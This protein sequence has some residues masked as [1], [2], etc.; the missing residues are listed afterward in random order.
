MITV[1]CAGLPETLFE[2]ELFGH[3]KG[4]FTGATQNK[5]GLL[6]QANDGT[7]FLDEIGDVPLGM[8]VK[9]LRL[10][11][12]GSYRVVG[13]TQVRSV[14]FRLICATHKNL[15]Q[16]VDIGKFREDLY[17]RINVFPINL[18][19]LSERQ[20]DIPLIANSLL[21]KLS[22]NKHYQLTEKS[23]IRLKQLTY[24]GN[25]RQLRNL[26]ERAIIYAKSNIIDVATIEQCIDKDLSPHAA[27]LKEIN[28]RWVDLKTQEKN[29]L[30][31][32][33]MHF[34]GDKALTAKHAGISVR[35]L[36]RKLDIS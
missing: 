36:Y 28:D 27:P 1:E 12:T 15:Q 2:S 7:L 23:A 35:S 3:V 8:Q 18:P 24:K 29:Y 32:M 22:P 30:S 14:N 10:I 21:N 20:D 33:L 26:L 9:L 31:K 17:Y 34:N 19:S 4:A 13:S 6:E 11:E 16:L 25:I 5:T